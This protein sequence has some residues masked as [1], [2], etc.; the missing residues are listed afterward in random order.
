MPLER[1]DRF[2]VM[3]LT[4]DGLAIGHVEQAQRLCAAG[5]RWIQ[6]RMKGAAPEHWRATAAEVATICRAH[7]AVC[8]VNDS[9]EVALAAGADGVHLGREDLDWPAARAQLGPDR[10]IGG[11]VNDAT[12]AER[13]RAA[14]CL[15]YVGIGPL[16]F[17]ATKRKLAPVLGLD[18]IRSLVPLLGNLPAWVIGGVEAADLPS[19]RA[20]G[21]AGVAVSSALYRGGRLEENFGAFVEAVSDTSYFAGRAARGLAGEATGSQPPAAARPAP[22]AS[23]FA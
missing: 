19:V 3:C 7:D 18:G 11:T 21:A 9:V 12:G 5:A 23:Y 1:A 13:A 10:L 2:P 17:T 4:Q 16:R 8:I 22:A 20:A 14:G 15:D 6:L